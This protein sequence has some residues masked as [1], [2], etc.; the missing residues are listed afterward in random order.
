MELS[1][2]DDMNCCF[3]ENDTIPPDP[4]KNRAQLAKK[5][6]QKLRQRM[7]TR[8]RN[9]IV[10]V[11]WRLLFRAKE[12]ESSIS[13]S[14]LATDYT[15]SLTGKTMYSWSNNSSRF[16]TFSCDKSMRDILRI[17]KA[18]VKYAESDVHALERALG[19]LCRTLSSSDQSV[20]NSNV[21]SINDL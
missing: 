19:E 5:R 11:R 17:V 16:V 14:K 6:R 4:D 8:L 15:T 12:I 9:V 2:V 1:I 21:L 3:E 20:C 18:D 13:A 7:L 10:V